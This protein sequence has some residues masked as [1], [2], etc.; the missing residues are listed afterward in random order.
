L[1]LA[2]AAAV[3]AVV[4][5]AVS[6]ATSMSTLEALELS[7]LA[8]GAAVVG[9]VSG[10]LM[11][12][13]TRT[14]GFAIQIVAVALVSLLSIVAG[15][16]A[17][18]EAMFLDEADLGALAVILVAATTVAASGAM[19]V[20]SRVGRAVDTLIDLTRRLGDENPDLGA[21]FESAPH[22]LNRLHQELAN[23]SMRL[24]LAHKRERALDASRRELVAWVSHDLRTPLAGI[25]ALAEA[26]EDGI[27]DDPETIVRYHTTLR[28]EADRLSGLVDDLFELSRTQA[29]VLRLEFERV[30]L[31][32]LVSDALA[33]ASLTAETKGVRL[34]GRLTGPAPEL[35]AAAPEV[36]RVLRNILENAIRHTPSDGTV[37]VEAG[38][39][40][41][42][43]YVKVRDTGGGIPEPDLPSV[44]DVAFRGAAARSPGDGAG[45][46]LAIARGLVEAHNGDISVCNE[47]GGAC[48]TIRLPLNSTEPE[49]C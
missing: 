1:A 31:A 41:D 25:R 6:R 43:A 5:V 21:D 24:D 16:W 28:V 10:A 7:A 4:I 3:P 12:Q 15:V 45:L 34:H 40:S 47:N 9:G 44:F 8:A 22:E 11:L 35:H 46:G 30:S 19:L 18:A 42:R 37:T 48:F 39:E 14:R 49:P 38:A 33:G 32:D 36:L 2:L 29:G 23:S 26:L 27:A 13:L 20:G 17:A